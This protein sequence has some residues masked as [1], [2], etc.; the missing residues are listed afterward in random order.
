MNQCLS[1]SNKA[2][3]LPFKKDSVLADYGDFKFIFFPDIH[4]ILP[5][6]TR[7]KLTSILGKKNRITVDYSALNLIF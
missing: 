7:A 4:V 5:H 2:L 6:T 1:L 3:E